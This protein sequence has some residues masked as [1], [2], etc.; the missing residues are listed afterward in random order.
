MGSPPGTCS[1]WGPFEPRKN[2]PTL[3]KAYLQLRSQRSMPDLVLAGQKGWGSDESLLSGPGIRSLGY[4]EERD[5]PALYSGATAFLMPS[6][7]EGYGMP[8]AEA[9]A[10]GCR[11]VATDIRELREA[12]GDQAIFV[13][14][15]GQHCRGDRTRN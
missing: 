15:R 6:L 12:A 10:C 11:V 1:A 2:I 9:R 14:R 13:S 4:V 3:V 5:L 7:Y 8:A